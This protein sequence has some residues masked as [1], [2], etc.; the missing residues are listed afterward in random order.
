MARAEFVTCESNRCLW[1]TNRLEVLEKCLDGEEGSEDAYIIFT[2]TII[3]GEV[4]RF[5]W[6]RLLAVRIVL[7]R[8]VKRVDL[9]MPTSRTSTKRYR[10]G[11]DDPGLS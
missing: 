1:T 4:A 2:T 7:P 5:E 11:V 3:F 8:L 6:Q 9:I 10:S